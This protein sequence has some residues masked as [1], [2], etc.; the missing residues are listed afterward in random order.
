LRLPSFIKCED[1][2]SISTERLGRRLG[3]V[4]A[5]TMAHVE[6]ILRALLDL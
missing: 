5:D 2:R 1:L 4:S 6:E 3:L